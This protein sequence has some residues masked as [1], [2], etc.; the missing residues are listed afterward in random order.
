MKIVKVKNYINEDGT[1]DYK[2]LDINSFV[3]AKQLYHPHHNEYCIIKTTEDRFQNHND[4]SIVSEEEYVL[5]KAEIDEISKNLVTEEMKR[6]RILEEENLT[7]MEAIA[8]IY[9]KTL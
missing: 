1:A 7:L 6:I 8:T 5:L 3:A 4:L 9:E 2:G